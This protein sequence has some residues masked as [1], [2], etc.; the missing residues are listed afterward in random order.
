MTKRRAP[1][2]DLAGNRRALLDASTSRYLGRVLR[3]EEGDSFVAFDPRSAVEADARVVGMTGGALLVEI[4]DLRSANVV[5]PRRITLVQ[6]LAKGEKCDAI[7][8]DATELGAT[9]IVF[10][11]TE[12]SIVDL[13]ADRVKDRIARW[14]RIAYEAA[15]QSLRG[16]APWITTSTWSEAM[17]TN[18][19]DAS[20]VLHPEADASASEPF[21][22][23]LS[24]AKRTLA[25]AVGPE[26]GLTAEELETA[27]KQ[28]WNA[29]SLGP[30]VLRTETVA[31]ALLG[32]A[33][34]MSLA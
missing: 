18:A 6:A 10:V 17:H 24:D 9:H 1:I 13:P 23:A 26:G 20:F 8:R 21:R 30:I 3:L 28:G 33:R 11:T 5:A 27:E 16:D 31:A 19:S 12:R 25:F 2:D 7:V 15:R 34:I 14:E 29:I 22:L 32:A 4:G